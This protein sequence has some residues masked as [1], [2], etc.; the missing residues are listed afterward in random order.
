VI[1]SEKFFDSPDHPIFI[2]EIVIG[3][4]ETQPD[5]R[6]LRIVLE[7]TIGIGDKPLILTVE[8]T[9]RLPTM[10]LGAVK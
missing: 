4:D 6:F 9:F 3:I 8:K 5:I 10:E 2:I 1:G 7:E